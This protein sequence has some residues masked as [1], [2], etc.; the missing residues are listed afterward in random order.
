MRAFDDGIVDVIQ[1]GRA[2]VA[3]AFAQTL[4][5]FG[6]DGMQTHF[7]LQ[8]SRLGVA[9]VTSRPNGMSAMRQ[10]HASSLFP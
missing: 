10:A 1:I 5:D 8:P 2:R 4:G 6:N 3:A 7:R 9:I